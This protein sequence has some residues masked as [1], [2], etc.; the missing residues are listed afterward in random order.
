MNHSAFRVQILHGCRKSPI[1]TQNTSADAM[2]ASN[3][4]FKLF[5]ESEDVNQ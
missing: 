3:L 2:I 4:I 1:T 5:D